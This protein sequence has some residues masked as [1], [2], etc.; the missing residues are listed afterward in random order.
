[1][2]NPDEDMLFES[3]ITSFLARRLLP[4]TGTGGSLA[5]TVLYIT[6][7]NPT[8]IQALTSSDSKE[9]VETWSR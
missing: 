6:N 3:T 4:N 2:A 1:M 8:M 7:L 5:K 9:K